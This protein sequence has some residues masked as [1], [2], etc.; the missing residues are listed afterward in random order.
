MPSSCHVMFLS[1]FRSWHRPDAWGNYGETSQVNPR[2]HS[3]EAEM[4][5]SKLPRPVHFCQCGDHAWVALTRGYVTL[6]SPED[7]H[8]LQER[9][10]CAIVDPHGKPS[11]AMADQRLHCK[12]LS[13]YPIDHKN[14]NGFDNR[15]HNLRPCTHAQNNANLPT[16]NKT[17]FRGVYKAKNKWTART[18]CVPRKRLGI[19]STAEEAARAYDIEAIRHW[20][21]FAVLNFPN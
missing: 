14:H 10:W 7:A 3:S 17:G 16:R 12:I 21:E 20:G 13:T 4:A 15:R 2:H 8:F 9:P 5:H 1:C 19:F 18:G 6:V 11:Y